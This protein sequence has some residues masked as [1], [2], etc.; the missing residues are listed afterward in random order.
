MK[1]FKSFMAPQLEGYIVYRQGLGYRD[2]HIRSYLLPFDRYLKNQKRRPQRFSPRFFLQF[3]T[4]LKETMEPQ[5]VNKILSVL[6]GLFQFMK[7]QGLCEYNPLEDIPR[8]PERWFVPFVFSEEQIDQLLAALCK[9]IR[10][11]PQYFFT[12]LACYMAAVLLARCGM[13]L[14]E[15]VRLLRRHYRREE[16]TLYIEKTKFNKDR[17]IPLPKAAWGELDNYLAVRKACF[18]DPKSPYLLAGKDHRGLTREQI[19]RRVRQAVKDIGLEQPRRRRGDM[20]FGAPTPHSLRHAFAINTLKRIR[21]KGKD[22]QHALPV[23]AAYLGHRK[24]KYTAAYLKVTDPKDVQG[25]IRYTKTRLDL[26]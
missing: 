20:T 18:G 7:R 2:G 25:L 17:L 24:Y 8:L 16:K 14:S 21:Q 13:R 10:K 9:R 12:D 15:P 3:R 26:V 11:C 4:E 1:P 23:L 22:P 6:R 19:Y 5:T